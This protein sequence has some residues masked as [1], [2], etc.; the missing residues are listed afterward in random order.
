M[1]A[2][3]TVAGALLAAPQA[4]AVTR[5]RE[6]DNMLA[7]GGREYKGTFVAIDVQDVL[8]GYAGRHVTLSFDLRGKAGQT[9]RIYAYQSSGISIASLDLSP[10][11]VIISE[12]DV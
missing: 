1:M 4:Q 5:Y 7:D 12:N 6:G 8:Q 10:M 9:V 3:L 11:A 2:A